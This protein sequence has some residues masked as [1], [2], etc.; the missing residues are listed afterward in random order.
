[1]EQ[2]IPGPEDSNF[3]AWMRREWGDRTST[4]DEVEFWKFVKL[5]TEPWDD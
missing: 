5:A 1:M 2:V 3:I 4:G